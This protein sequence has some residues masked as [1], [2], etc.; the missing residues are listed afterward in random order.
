[1]LSLPPS[2][3]IFVARD[4]ADMRKGFDGLSPLVCDVAN[5]GSAVRP[6]VCLRQPSQGTGEDPLGGS[7]WILTALQASRTRS[8]SVLRS[9]WS[10]A[11][12]R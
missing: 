7:I 10:T 2:M 12:H 5:G 8:L 3:R 1:M 4:P 9:S 6:P 11:G